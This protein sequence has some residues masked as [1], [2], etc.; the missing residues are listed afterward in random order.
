MGTVKGAS[1]PVPVDPRTKP[2]I[3]WGVWL[4]FGPSAIGS[5]WIIGS[6][7]FAIVNAGGGASNIGERIAT[8]LLSAL[9]GILSIWAL[10]SVTAR[11]FKK[12]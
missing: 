11:Y 5:L 7:V 9:Y 3:F 8:T 6:N 2:V 12:D 1:Y 4:Y 10:W